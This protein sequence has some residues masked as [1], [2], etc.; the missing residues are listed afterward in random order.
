MRAIGVVKGDA[1]RGELQLPG[2]ADA[3]DGDVS[4]A[5]GGDVGRDVVVGGVVVVEAELALHVGGRGEGAGVERV[6]GARA[7]VSY[8]TI[9]ASGLFA[10]TRS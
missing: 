7:Q 10:L 3:G 2:V 9:F 6:A 4:L 5:A 8:S 1:E